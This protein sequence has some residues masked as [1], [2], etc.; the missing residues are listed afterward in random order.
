VSCSEQLALLLEPDVRH[1]GI[2]AVAEQAKQL[3]P[4]LGDGWG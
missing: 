3:D 2:A 4:R 1:H